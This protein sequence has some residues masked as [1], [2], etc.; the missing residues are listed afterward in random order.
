MARAFKPT[1]YTA[2]YAINHTYN[3]TGILHVHQYPPRCRKSNVPHG[4]MRRR[5]TWPALHVP[6]MPTAF[7]LP[8]RFFLRL[9]LPAATRARYPRTFFLKIE[10]RKRQ[11]KAR[12]GRKTQVASQA[13]FPPKQQQCASVCC[14]SV[15][16]VFS[17]K[18]GA[19]SA[20]VAGC[21]LVA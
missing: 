14:R 12:R 8:L 1:L 16:V 5:H 17:R 3:P 20:Y 9:L 13:R 4:G 11:R 7:L 15:Q 6:R 18:S 21:T 10:G 19:V 2:V